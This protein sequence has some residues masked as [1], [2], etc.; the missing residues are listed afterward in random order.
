MRPIVHPTRRRVCCGLAAAGTW[1]AGSPRSRAKAVDSAAT[2]RM[3]DV[4]TAFHDHRYRTPYKFGGVPVD[5]VT[6]LDVEIDTETADGRI[7][8][9]RGSM[10][11]GNVWAFPSKSLPY[12]A[13]LDAMKAVVAL[14]ARCLATCPVAAHP[15]EL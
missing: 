14:I 8:T 2:V 12:Q 1:L 11:L 10:P 6:L 4:R 5:R 13:T 7:V 3:K 9:G 15:L